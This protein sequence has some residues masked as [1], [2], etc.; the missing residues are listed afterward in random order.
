M[1]ATTLQLVD[2]ATVPYLSGRF[3]P[4]HD[5]ISADRL[6]VEGTIP[7][8]L[9]GAYLRNGPNPEFT[10]L[11]SYTYPLEGDGMVHGVWIEDG[12]A[13]YANR[14]VRTQ[15]LR[16][17][18]RAGRAL[19]GGLMTPAFVDQALLGDDPDPTWPFKLDAYINVV[20]H[21][22]RYLALG[23]GV[24]PYE[25]TAAL[26]TVG[27]VD[28]G[29]AL[30]SG[31]CAHPK[32]DPVSGEM[33]VFRYDVQ[34]PFLTWATLGADGTVTQPT[35]PVHGVDRSFM[36]HDFAITPRHVVLVVAPLVIDADAMLAGGNP[37]A[38]HPELGTR[39]AVIPRDRATPTRWVHTDAFWTWHYAN[40]YEADDRIYL[41]FPWVTAPQLVPAAGDR[42]G[43]EAGFTRAGLDPDHGTATLHHLDARG[44]EFPRIDDRLVGLPHRY[45]TTGSGGETMQLG[46]HNRIHQY[47]MVTGTSRTA[48]LDMVVGEVQF[49]PRDGS[50]SELDGYYLAFATD[51]SGPQSFLVIWDAGEFP[52]PPVARISIPHRVPNGLHGNWFAADAKSAHPQLFGETADVPPSGRKVGGSDRKSR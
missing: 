27:R 21:G 42:A 7:S 44:T 49:A 24:P 35:V 2:P 5:E 6:T 20:R 34:A 3:A 15:S 8:D 33:V 22:R 1:A 41:D 38:W 50:T 26:D 31:M 46:E 4:I 25:I 36:I 12:H 18:E 43:V 48:E 9:A 28:F 37:I 30:P 40:A 29:D 51:L 52:A 14:W 19:F 13:R 16:A 11:G 17:E 39:I 45:V 23:E 32:I 10:P 47:D